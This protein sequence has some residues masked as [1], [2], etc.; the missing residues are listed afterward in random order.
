[1]DGEDVMRRIVILGCSGTGKST[2]AR[3]LAAKLNLPIAHLD[4][5]FFEPGWKPRDRE[6]FRRKVTDATRLERWIV[7]GNFVSWV[8]DIVLPRADL[9][10]W[11]E[12]PRWLCLLRV[13]LRCLDPRGFG[14]ADLPPGCRDSLSQNMLT[15]IWT[16]ERVARHNI[17]AALTAHAPDKRVIHL[18]GNQEITDYLAGLDQTD[19][20]SAP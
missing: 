16:F 1:M 5:L 12:Q 3:N 2:L 7:D 6:D 8:G 11:L 9:I 4:H 14:R 13:T 18:Y 19:Q 17:E 20:I 10:L 15:F